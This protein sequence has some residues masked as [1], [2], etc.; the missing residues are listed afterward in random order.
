MTKR[1]KGIVTAVAAI[2]ALATGGAVFAQAQN[3]ST[4]QQAPAAE[5]GAPE[6]S[7]TDKDNVQDENG[8]DDAS[9]KPEKGEKGDK[10]DKADKAEQAGSEVPGD[11]GPGGHAD[12]PGN[13]NAD[14]QSQGQL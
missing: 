2:A 10:A 8:K 6:N 5:K 1:W 14:N 13:P 11:D 3:G 4:Q 12:E 9:E 7:A